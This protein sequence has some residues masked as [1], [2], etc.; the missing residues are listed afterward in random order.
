MPVSATRLNRASPLAVDERRAMIIDAVIP[1]LLEHG[2]DVT[3]RQIAGAAGVAEGTV[4]RAF[5]DKNSLIRAAVERYLESSSIRQPLTDINPHLPLEDKIR[6]A[7]VVLQTGFRGVF[8]MVSILGEH[9]HPRSAEDRKNTNA[10][11]S[12]LFEP[13][14]EA[15]NIPPERVAKLLRWICFASSLPPFN[16]GEIYTADELTDMALYGIVGAPSSNRRPIPDHRST[17]ES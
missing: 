17:T 7:V 16:D 15:L 11:F 12:Q 1:L 9:P 10:L 6:A 4:F 13:D 5:G 3:S 2:A 8:R 14:L